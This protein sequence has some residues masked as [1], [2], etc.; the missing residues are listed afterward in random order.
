MSSDCYT[1]DD[2]ERVKKDL[3]KL[4]DSEARYSGNNPDKY[5]AGIRSLVRQRDAIADELKRQGLLP[6]EEE[7]ALTRRLDEVFP[8]ARNRQVVEFE[9]A[10]YRK[11]FR[12]AGHSR[13][14][15]T[16]TDWEHW[17]EPV[18]TL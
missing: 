10:R 16:V 7:E 4:V 17:W 2:L 13:S 1:V 9:G 12:P 18:D 8:N 6:E 5:T 11:R 3:A 14:G 15:K